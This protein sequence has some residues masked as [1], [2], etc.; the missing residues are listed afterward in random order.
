M[1]LR[2]IL[3][4]AFLLAALLMAV[5]APALAAK[6]TKTT[7]F[8][9]G[10]SA[11][12]SQMDYL[13]IEDIDEEIDAGGTVTNL[14]SSKRSVASIIAFARS[15]NEYIYS[16]ESTALLYD[17]PGIFLNIKKPGDTVIS[18]KI[19]GEAYTKGGAKIDTAVMRRR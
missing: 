14:K 1:K 13:P 17:Q 15:I 2:R 18:M 8:Y 11:Y 12:D 19:N 5:A 6:A 4:C 3:I 10:G 9:K 7:T 16:D